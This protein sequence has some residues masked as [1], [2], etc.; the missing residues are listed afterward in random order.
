MAK[1]SVLVCTAGIILERKIVSRIGLF[2][3][4]DRML[5]VVILRGSSEE[6][7]RRPKRKREVLK[8]F[9]ETGVWRAA[10]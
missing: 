9:V 10:V 2:R 3:R 5:K 6:E 4:V 1:A 7:M 8:I